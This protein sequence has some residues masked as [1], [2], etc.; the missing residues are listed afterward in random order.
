MKENRR[1]WTCNRLDLQ[2]LG[3]RRLCLQIS[4]ITD[5]NAIWLKPLIHPSIHPSVHLHQASGTLWNPSK[6][7]QQVWIRYRRLT[8]SPL[9]IYIYI[10][11]HMKGHQKAS[12]KP[13]DNLVVDGRKEGKDGNEIWCNLVWVYSFTGRCWSNVGWERGL[14]T[15]RERDPL[16]VEDFWRREGEPSRH[17]AKSGQHLTPSS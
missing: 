5:E 17:T 6:N 8:H 11:I 13:H 1:M 7:H 12:G 3:S 16:M 15:C 10:Y 9:Y 4:P 2:T 14:G